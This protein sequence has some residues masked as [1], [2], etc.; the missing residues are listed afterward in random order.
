[1]AEFTFVFQASGT[2]PNKLIN[3]VPS[4]GPQSSPGLPPLGHGI[5]SFG[6]WSLSTEDDCCGNWRGGDLEPYA[7]RAELE[8]RVS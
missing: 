4:A 1:M 2:K 8:N 5:A 3:A 6:F 7:R